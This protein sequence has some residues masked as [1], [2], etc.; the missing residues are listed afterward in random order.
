MTNI[1]R[2]AETLDLRELESKAKNI[3]LATTI[4]S[5]RANQIS[6]KLKEE[7]KNRLEPFLNDSDNLEEIQENREQIEISLLYERQ[8]KPTL[9]AT[10]EFLE[11]KTYWRLPETAKNGLTEKKKEPYGRKRWHSRLQNT[12]A[13]QA[14]EKAG[15]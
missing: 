3:Y 7:L 10:Q 5:R 14:P 11:D 9:Q 13:H 6:E 8:P 1:K 4:I 2:N 12:N 15:R